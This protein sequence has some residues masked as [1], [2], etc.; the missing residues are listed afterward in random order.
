[1]M[2]EC[3]PAP[4][5]LS[6]GA[7]LLTAAPWPGCPPLELSDRPGFTVGNRMIFFYFAF[8]KEEK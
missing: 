6:A 8:L 7:Q 1:M 2:L 5:P 3:W 4:W